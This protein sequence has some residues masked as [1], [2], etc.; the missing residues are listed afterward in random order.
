[1]NMTPAKQGPNTRNLHSNAFVLLCVVFFAGCANSGVTYRPT[2]QKLPPHIKRIAVRPF[3]NK[4]PQFR[5]EDKL[6]LRVIDEFL[7]NGEYRIVPEASADGIV[8][9]EISRYILT[10]VQYDANLVPTV[11]KLDVLLSV[12]FL[13]KAYNTLLWHEPAL[14][15][16]QNYSASTLPGGMTEEEARE[17]IWN[18]LSRDIVKRTVEG[19]GSVT[20]A[21]ERRISPTAPVVSTGTVSQPQ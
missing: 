4:T 15:G 19:F 6:T 9:G 21:S 3:V 12:K 8:L 5:L 14:Q 2:A 7:K 10:P 13:D 16:I 18:I 20:S 11:Y 1:M 17:V